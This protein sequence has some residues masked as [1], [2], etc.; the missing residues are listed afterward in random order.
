[1]RRD[2]AQAQER[3][4]ELGH[5]RDHLAEGPRSEKKTGFDSSAGNTDQT[6]RHRGGYLD[7]GILIAFHPVQGW[8]IAYQPLNVVR[9]RRPGVR[10][11][12]GVRATLVHL[13]QSGR[14]VPEDPLDHVR[15]D[16]EP[17]AHVRRNGS[18][19][20]WTT[21]GRSSAGTEP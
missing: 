15:L 4:C 10:G 11:L 8:P 7:R 17:L 3:R 6:A 1:M 16:P 20:S 21:Y 18:A 14:L 5:R 12:G 2:V 9:P 13:L 19:M